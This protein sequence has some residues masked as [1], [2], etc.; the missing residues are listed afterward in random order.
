MLFFDMLEKWSNSAEKNSQW[1]EMLSLNM[2]RK[3][4]SHNTTNCL[5]SAEGGCQDSHIMSPKLKQ[6]LLL[7][8]EHSVFFPPYGNT[9]CVVFWES[10]FLFPLDAFI[11]YPPKLKL[12]SVKHANTCH[13][14]IHLWKEHLKIKSCLKK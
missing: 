14:H 11:V 1:G 7:C 10:L 9:S 8:T 4:N 6:L 3:G 5:H 13:S 12:F 2:S